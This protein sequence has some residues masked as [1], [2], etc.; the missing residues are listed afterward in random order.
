MTMVKLKPA[1]SRSQVNCA[2]YNGAN[3]LSLSLSAQIAMLVGYLKSG[4][5][6]QL[7]K[8]GQRPCFFFFQLLA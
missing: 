4:K 2:L 8:F 7:A 1:L 6:G 3:A 5:F